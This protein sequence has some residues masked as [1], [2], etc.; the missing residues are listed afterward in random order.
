MDEPG[1]QDVTL[2]ELHALIAAHMEWERGFFTKELP[3]L[4][5]PGQTLT[6]PACGSEILSSI[7]YGDYEPEVYQGRAL[8]QKF[9]AALE[10]AHDALLET[11][12]PQGKEALNKYMDVLAARGSAVA[13]QAYKSGFRTAVQ[14]LVAGLTH[15]GE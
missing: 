5:Q 14:L 2:A 10:Q 12:S 3:L 1:K 4:V 11:L 15:P 8:D 6:P 9:S 7:Y 13:E